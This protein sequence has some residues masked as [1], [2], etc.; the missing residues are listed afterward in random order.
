MSHV[1]VYGTLRHGEPNHRLIDMTQSTYLGTYVKTLPYKMVSLGGFPG[2]VDS[3]LSSPIV[4]ELYDVDD[5]TFEKLDTLEGYPFF[6]NRKK[7]K[8]D[9]NV[10]AWI[11][12]LNDPVE[13]SHLPVIYSGDWLNRYE[14][15][16]Y[17]DFNYA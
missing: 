12:Y 5:N 3:E 15:E 17:G 16:I 1:L 10:Y 2:L 14:E 7:I 4:V 13:Y 11:Y 9:D 8:I 6:Y